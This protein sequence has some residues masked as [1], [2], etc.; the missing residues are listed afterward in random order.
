MTRNPVMT[1]LVFPAI[2]GALCIV[3]AIVTGT[4]TSGAYV[5]MFFALPIV[6]TLL[7]W[8]DLAHFFDERKKT[9][10]RRASR[11]HEHT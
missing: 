11:R 3:L 1:A 6:V 2:A 8:P 10:R 9:G 4:G 5:F 7:M